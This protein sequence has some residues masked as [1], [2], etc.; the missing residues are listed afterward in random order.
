M[1]L[2]IA[3]VV[4]LVAAGFLASAINGVAGGGSLVSFPALMLV[5]YPAVVA[6]VTN[7]VA[8][9]PGYL[10]ATGVSREQLASQQRRIRVLAPIGVAGAV[11]GAFLLTRT[12]S[13]SF[14]GVV[15][16]LILVACGLLALQPQLAARIGPTKTGSDRLSAVAGPQFLSGLYGGFFGAG[17]GVMLLATLG[18]F[19]EDRLIRLN[20]LKQLLSL[21]ISAVAALWFAVFGPVAW[22]AVALVALGSVGGGVVGVM[23][24]R[25]LPPD[26]LRLAMV[27]F[28]VA[29]AIRML[30]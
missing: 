8:L 26:L 24:A 25:R 14:R 7:T 13:N 1:H 16:W 6:N 12:S 2:D 28:G 4:L 21:L 27:L 10:G 11:M 5:G 23:V 18:I 20:A 9:I 30:V 29:V 15:P 3:N 17:L 22:N 19:L